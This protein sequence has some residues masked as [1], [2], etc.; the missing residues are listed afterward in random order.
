MFPQYTDQVVTL[1][2]PTFFATGDA[3]LTSIGFPPGAGSN[4]ARLEADGDA[5][6][7]IGNVDPGYAISIAQE[8]FPDVLNK[9]SAIIA[10]WTVW[11]AWT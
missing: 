11:M 3:F 6:H 7:L 2:A 9:L 10:A 1:N 4:I 5:V 8:E